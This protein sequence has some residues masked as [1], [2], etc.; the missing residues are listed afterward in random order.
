MCNGPILTGMI[1]FALPLA[2]S[3]ILQL[4][5]NAADVIVIGQFGSS[6]SLAA[7]GADALIASLFSNIFLNLATGA[8]VWASKYLGAGKAENVHD[9][10][11]TSIVFSFITGVLFTIAMYFCSRPF[12]VLL[13]TPESVIPLAMQYLYYYL[14]SIPGTAIYNFGSALLRAKGDTKRPFFF[15]LAAGIINVFLNL[16]FVLVCKMDVAGVA[17]ATTISQYISTALI[18]I[19]LLREKDF[20]KL[21]IRDLHINKTALTNILKIGI[22]AALQCSVFYISNFVIQSAINGF[23]PV[24]MAGNAA[25]S[26][27]ELFVWVFMCGFE[28][29]GMSY[30]SQNLGAN[31]RKR[32]DQSFN[33]SMICT[34]IT[35]IV[36][37]LLVS[38]FARFFI[39]LYT[40]DVQAADQGIIRMH[41]ILTTYFLCGIMDCLTANIRGFGSSLAPSIISIF[42]AC[43]LRIVWIFTVFQIP[44]FHTLFCLFLAYPLSWTITSLML[45]V[46]YIVVRNKNALYAKSLTNPASID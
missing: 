36:L 10:L 9:I 19:C 38:F 37:G 29:V 5:F 7:V 34:T 2:F 3:S 43:I 39:S 25:G 20:F 1:K 4:L 23:G 44:Q 33:L 42:G 22:P 16:F 8:T 45:A 32:V 14:P 35:G 28:Q 26:N 11:H 18:L 15:L 13:K 41:I 6:V 30:I 21:I 12:L 40:A 46:C 17:L 24:V 31:N 27:I